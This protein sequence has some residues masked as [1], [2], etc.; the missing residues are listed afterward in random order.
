[1]TRYPNQS[2][3]LLGS[4]G[5]WPRNQGNGRELVLACAAELRQDSRWEVAV[6]GAVTDDLVA[7]YQSVGLTPIAPLGGIPKRILAVEL[8]DRRSNGKRSGSLP[9]EES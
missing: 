4:L 8:R 5:A 6:A 3:V 7:L 9:A 1:V 2:M